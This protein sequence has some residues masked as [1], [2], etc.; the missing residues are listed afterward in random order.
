LRR[1][2]GEELDRTRTSRGVFLD[3][4]GG[5]RLRGESERRGFVTKTR[6]G[7]REIANESIISRLF[8]EER[9]QLAARLSPSLLRNGMVAGHFLR[10][11]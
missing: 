6:V 4:D 1:H 11:A 2:T 8:F 10:P 7:Q 3:R 9:F 5:H